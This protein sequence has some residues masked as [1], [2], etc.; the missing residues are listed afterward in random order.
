MKLL[1]EPPVGNVPPN[2]LLYPIISP[3]FLIISCS[4]PTCTPAILYVAIELLINATNKS[5]KTALLCLPPYNW[6]KNNLEDDFGD[7]KRIL[8]KVFL[9]SSSDN[10]EYSKPRSIVLCISSGEMDLLTG[11]FF[12]SSKKSLIRILNKSRSFLISSFI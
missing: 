7:F 12:S 5:P 10:G 8:R 2:E 4:I 11:T 6:L 3:T 1:M 9:K